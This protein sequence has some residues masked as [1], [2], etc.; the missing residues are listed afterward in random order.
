MMRRF[1]NGKVYS[2]VLFFAFLAVTEAG[3]AQNIATYAGNGIAGYSGDGAAATA[4]KL[5]GPYSIA[6]SNTGNIYFS[7]Y[8]NGIVRMVSAAGIIST[9]AGPGTGTY[10]GFYTDSF[11]GSKRV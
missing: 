11:H 7:E 9:I 8:G 1:F 3:I 4:A 10:C 5:N 6:L 2:I